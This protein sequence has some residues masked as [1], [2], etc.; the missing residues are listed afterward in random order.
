[1]K[2]GE[3]FQRIVVPL[4]NADHRSFPQ[5]TTRT[6]LTDPTKRTVKISFDNFESIVV[7]WL[8]AVGTFSDDEDPE[9]I[10][11]DYDDF[12]DTITFKFEIPER[13]L[14]LPLGDLNR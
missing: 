6:S 2:E 7:A 10:D 13:Q 1:M 9:I 4:R 14:R 3:Y 12:D 5:S 8:A 11:F